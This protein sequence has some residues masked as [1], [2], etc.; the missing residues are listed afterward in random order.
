ME[1]VK[2]A[3]EASKTSGG[4]AWQRLAEI[5]ES[6]WEA[7]RKEEA[8]SLDAEGGDRTPTDIKPA[9][10][11]AYWRL[12]TESVSGLISKDTPQNELPDNLI[13]DERLGYAL[14]YGVLTDLEGFAWAR[15][16]V[17]SFFPT[18]P[19][20]DRCECFYVTQ[21]INQAYRDIRKVDILKKLNDQLERIKTAIEEEPQIREL[22]IKNRNGSVERLVDTPSDKEKLIQFFTQIDNELETF[23]MME[24]KMREG[25]FSGKEERQRYISLTQ[26]AE[27]RQGQIDFI[28]ERQPQAAEEVRRYHKESDESLTQL[29]QLRD[30]K[31][32]KEKDIDQ[33][34]SAVRNISVIDIKAGLEEEVGKLKGNGRLTS[35]LGKSMQI[36]LPLEERDIITPDKAYKALEEIEEMDP[37]LFNNRGV[38]RKGKPALF[39][40]P[41]IG[42]GIYDW[43]GHR[44]LIPTMYTRSILGS[45]ASAVVLYRV[46]V[47]QSYNDREL[48]LSYKNDI[49]DN[50]KIRSMIKLRQQLIK[51]YL[52]W[53]TKEAKGFPLM[54]KQSRIWF[55]YRI[56]PNKYEP[57]FPRDMH[58]LTLKAQ[59]E[60]LEAELKKEENPQTLFRQALFYYLMDGENQDVLKDQIYA[61]LEKALEQDPGNLDVIY[62]L[63]T[64]YRKNKNKRCIELFV[65]YT[66]KAPQS[67]WSKKALELVTTFK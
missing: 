32:Q 57:K 28:L 39:I 62:S 47:D 21:T 12:M 19:K 41:G 20:N 60:G 54:E 33:E 1:E 42:E 67:W 9:L 22:A 53:I 31:R 8:G 4:E 52:L 40:V 65:D 66:K 11:T 48:I 64:I 35:K 56:A 5:V 46:D 37:N 17:A 23:K 55:E 59:R 18:P 44:L 10:D 43:E 2:P 50:K 29:I 24:K 38:K 13:F 25:G 3:E 6:Y 15:E 61:R 27:E 7:L 49:K 16:K 51:E 63:G 45:V 26:K 30:E 58:G 36:S 14:C 34:K